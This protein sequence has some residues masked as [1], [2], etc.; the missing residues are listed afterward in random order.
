MS[1]DLWLCWIFLVMWLCCKMLVLL[2]IRMNCVNWLEFFAVITTCFSCFS[3]YL[4]WRAL[5]SMAV[6]LRR[7]HMRNKRVRPLKL[8][9]FISFIIHGVHLETWWTDEFLLLNI[10]RHLR[11]FRSATFDGYC[12]PLDASR[13]E[14]DYFRVNCCCRSRALLRGYVFD[15]GKLL[16]LWLI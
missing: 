11:H 16:H 15:R 8:S 4:N 6:E 1:R 2:L 14:V 7:K 5:R 10:S 9:G 12:F 3:D 13:N